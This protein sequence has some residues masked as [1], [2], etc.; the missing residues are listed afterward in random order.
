MPTCQPS[1]S[2]YSALDMPVCEAEG[3]HVPPDPFQSVP[4]FV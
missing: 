4:L 3:S 2:G 1:L